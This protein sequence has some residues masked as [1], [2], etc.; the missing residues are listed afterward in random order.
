MTVMIRAIQAIQGVSS[1]HQRLLPG[2]GIAYELI[3]VRTDEVLFDNISNGNL[4]PN[5]AYREGDPL[6][7]AGE[8]FD[9]TLQ[10]IDASEI[11]P[12]SDLIAWV[13]PTP[14]DTYYWWAAVVGVVEGDDVRFVGQLASEYDEQLQHVATVLGVSRLDAFLTLGTEIAIATY[15]PPETRAP[16]MAAID[17]LFNGPSYDEIWHGTD[18][19]LRGLQ[20]DSAPPDVWA[21]VESRR[22]LFDIP[23]ELAESDELIVVVRSATGV[24][25][26][27]AARVAQR[28]KL[29]DDTV[30]GLPGEDLEIAL[31]S[32]EDPIGEA[33]GTVSYAQWS[34]SEALMIKISLVD[35]VAA[36][37]VTGLTI[38]EFRN[39]RSAD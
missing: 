38:D 10:Y 39:A 3:G 6:P 22:A 15:N 5:Q 18:P 9:L 32:H 4:K 14:S 27:L 29:P 31:T 33:I 13:L 34:E 20:D 1:L 25:S 28:V 17:N 2:L 11:P 12:G 16:A 37:D 21:Q 36:A 26:S 19:R 7:T 23:A 8:E 30:A 35:G 24:S